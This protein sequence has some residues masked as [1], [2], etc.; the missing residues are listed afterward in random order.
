MPG[1]PGWLSDIFDCSFVFD[2][3]SYTLVPDGCSNLRTDEKAKIKCKFWNAD[4]TKN[5]CT[6][7]PCLFKH[8]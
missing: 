7:N 3:S 2:E 8:A 1:G 6:G 5:N 4:P